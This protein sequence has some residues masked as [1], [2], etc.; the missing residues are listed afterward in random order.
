MLIPVLLA[1]AAAVWLFGKVTGLSDVPEEGREDHCARSPACLAERGNA[2]VRCRFAVAYAAEQRGEYRWHDGAE[3]PAF[4]RVTAGTLDTLVLTGD[5]LSIRLP[6][7]DWRT[8][9]Y[10][11][12]FN[13]AADTVDARLLD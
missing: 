10:S 2:H 9:N 7:T 4:P 12:R 1:I 8:Q 3:R 5:A 6:G 11:C 13:H